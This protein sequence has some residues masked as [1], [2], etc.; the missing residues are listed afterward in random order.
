MI[1]CAHKASS[2]IL[3]FALSLTALHREKLQSIPSEEQQKHEYYQASNQRKNSG[4]ITFVIL[5]FGNLGIFLLN[6]GEADCF[7]T[8]LKTIS[9]NFLC[10]KIQESL[11]R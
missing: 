8:R 10:L 5:V 3:T 6:T 11:Y 7:L 4:N 9:R 1:P 2:G